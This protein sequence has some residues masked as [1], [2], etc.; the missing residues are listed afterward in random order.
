MP[1]YRVFLVDDHPIVRAGFRSVID[2]E[3]DLV[4]VG[5][6]ASSEDA[7]RQL[8]HLVADVVVA[9]LSLE[10]ANGLELVKALHASHPGLPVLIVS[11]HDEALYAQRALEAGARGYLR[12]DHAVDALCVAIRAVVQGRVH[13]SP[14][15]TSRMLE[16][17]TSGQADGPTGLD[18]LT[19]RELEVLERLG[20][21]RPTREVAE[22][23][24]LSVKTIE[25]HRANIKAKLGLANAAE[26]SRQAVLFKQGLLTP[27]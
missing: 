18:A 6:A 17:V 25:T 20:E 12:K 9:D 4:A 27:R 11:M 22:L 8:A 21:G 23:L 5:E 10:G 2:A 7:Q 16:Q 15:M 24:H 26:L 3:D 13:L 1:R 14:A 19:D